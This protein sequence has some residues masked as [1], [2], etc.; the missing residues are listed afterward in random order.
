MTPYRTLWAVLVSAT[1]VLPGARAASAQTSN[2]PSAQTPGGPSSER[3]GSIV[4]IGAGGALHRIPEGRVTG[5]S[6]DRSAFAVGT[7]FRI[8]YAP[9]DQFLVYYS[10]KTA[11]TRATDY[12]AVGLSGLGARMMMYGDGGDF[13]HTC[14][15]WMLRLTCGLPA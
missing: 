2:V 11:F 5:D 3:K 9:T 8:G 13:G 1:L 7:D 15:R 14:M 12:D 6:L 10:A 4:G